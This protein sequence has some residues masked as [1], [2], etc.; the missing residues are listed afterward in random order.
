MANDLKA[1]PDEE[2]DM[3]IKYLCK[4]S[5]R[6]AINFRSVYVSDPALG[7]VKIWEIL[8]ERYGAPE[9]VKHAVVTKSKHFPTITSKDQRNC[10]N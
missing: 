2:T 5:K 3:L 1:S 10:M 7:L 8:D 4:E 9:L 6:H